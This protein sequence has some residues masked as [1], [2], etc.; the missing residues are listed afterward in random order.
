MSSILNKLNRNREEL[1]AQC[2]EIGI[3]PPEETDNIIMPSSLDLNYGINLT[4]ILISLIAIFMI[5]SI[6]FTVYQLIIKPISLEPATPPP[7][8]EITGGPFGFIDELKQI[9]V[10]LGFSDTFAYMIVL[11]MLVQIA[12]MA[13]RMLTPRLR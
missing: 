13:F 6:P 12:F 8:V 1:V 4:K 2:N 7:E 9:F 11:F 3:K 5:V 10:G